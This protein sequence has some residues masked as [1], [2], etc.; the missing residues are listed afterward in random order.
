MPGGSPRCFNACASRGTCIPPGICKC[1][2]PHS[3]YDC[4]DN[5]REDP[6][7]ASGFIYVYSPPNDYGL[8]QTRRSHFDAL[9]HAEQRFFE[10]LMSDYSLRTLDPNKA[11]LFYVPTWLIALYSNTVYDKGVHH[12]EALVSALSNQSDIFAAAWKTNRSRHLFFLAGDKGACLWPRGPIYLSHWG[13]TTPWKAMMLPHLWRSD[14][15]VSAR[16]KE[17]PCA[18]ERDLILPP[19]VTGGKPSHPH[20]RGG[21][22][23][24]SE[25]SNSSSSSTQR[26][27]DPPANGWSCEL[28][29][30]GAFKAEQK[31]QRSSWCDDGARGGVKCYSQGVRGAV[32]YHHQNRTEPYVNGG[33]FACLAPRLPSDLYLTSRFCLA[34]SGEGFGDRL[35]TSMLRGCVPLIIQ[36]GV[37]QP[38]DDIL[39]YHKFS[40]RVGADKIPIL[41]KLLPSITEAEHKRLRAG[42]RHYAAAFDWSEN[43]GQAY[44]LAAY[45][46]CRRAHHHGADAAAGKHGSGGGEGHIN[47]CR[48]LMPLMLSSSPPHEGGHLRS[49][50]AFGDYNV[51][52]IDPTLV[53]VPG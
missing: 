46:L 23:S 15:L 20:T 18:D 31:V 28:F 33:K 19:V 41:H 3:G 40:V 49:P 25:A 26:S 13:L 22:E 37:L 48:K 52:Q 53:R 14:V 5:V 6:A 21:G 7:G 29:F 17:A 11:R 50:T 12:F 8:A 16:A 35:A 36:P 45:A 2:P 42:V 47:P 10:R 51:G 34:P 1:T 39:P 30:A 38:Y 24:S 43:N 44:Q 9:Y 27:L 32:F 4:S